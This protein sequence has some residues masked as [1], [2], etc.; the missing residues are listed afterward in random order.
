[1]M[2]RKFQGIARNIAL[3]GGLVLVFAGCQMTAPTTQPQTE[4][5]V[6]AGG[7]TQV[8]TQ[9]NA[10]VSGLVTDAN[11]KP[12]AGV[13]VNTYNGYRTTTDANGKYTIPAVAQSQLRLD[14]SKDGYLV[15]QAVTD[16]TS[17]QTGN[18]NISLKPE[19]AKVTHI[20]AAAGGSAVSSDGSSIL[21]IP[22]G[23]LSKDA[24]VRVTWLDPMPSSNFTS[25]YGQLPGPL[26]TKTLV[27]GSDSDQIVPLNPLGFSTVDLSA[28]LKPG[29]EATLKMKVNPAALQAVNG[30]INFS[31]PA[32]LQQPC[33]EFDRAT[34]LWVTPSTSKLEKDADGTV[35]FVYT[36]HSAQA[37]PANY[38]ALSTGGSSQQLN[39]SAA[40][41]TV[42]RVVHVG[43]ST[44]TYYNYSGQV[45]EGVNGSD[46]KTGSW[47]DGD[48]T[49]TGTVQGTLS[50]NGDPFPGVSITTGFN[51]YFIPTPAPGSTATQQVGKN[52][53]F[54]GATQQA[55]KITATTNANGNFGF[56]AAGAA[57]NVT[58]EYKNLLIAHG[59]SAP[60][61]I[62]MNSDCSETLTLKGVFGSDEVGKTATLQYSIDGANF[63]KSNVAL[64]SA[65][66][67]TLTFA[68]N[69]QHDA[70][71]FKLTSLETPDEIANNVPLST[72]LFPGAQGKATINMAFKN[73][74]AK[75]RF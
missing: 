51:D 50:N 72:S 40:A 52:G 11:G 70:V 8:A 23:A 59:S 33:Y 47:S 45:L 18:I 34:G 58:A 30:Q 56:V 71:T 9:A 19:D 26:E 21:D 32:T 39:W 38:V 64:N 75:Y 3:T 44:I 14:F 48:I 74:A 28:D 55:N 20:T 60:Y 69:K 6:T 24:D 61:H 63:T 65:G 37:A 1:M 12:L 67:I 43:G 10:S 57:P 46:N 62:L 31:D 35:W 54:T 4:H 42:N 73:G 49:A 36:L 27:D 22:P 2:D 16:V 25:P 13:E 17:G 15:H 68:R 41:T 66:T 5:N 29:A 7:Q 53:L